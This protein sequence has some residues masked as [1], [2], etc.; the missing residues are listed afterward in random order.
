MEQLRAEGRHPSDSGDGAGAS[1]SDPQHVRQAGGGIPFG[2]TRAWSEPGDGSSSPSPPVSLAL[3]GQPSCTAAVAPA[4]SAPDHL[5]L[6]PHGDGV[7]LR[8]GDACGSGGSS[9]GWE[10]GGAAAIG[11]QAE[12]L[13]LKQRLA[14]AR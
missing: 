3:W 4:Y 2:S 11:L 10:V 7:S 6:D 12:V 8:R 13:Q 14:H 9:R 1:P 5:V